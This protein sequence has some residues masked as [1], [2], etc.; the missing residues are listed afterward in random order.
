MDRRTARRASQSREE[1]IETE[2]KALVIDSHRQQAKNLNSGVE[3]VA[4]VV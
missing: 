2:M 3:G 4:A 1:G